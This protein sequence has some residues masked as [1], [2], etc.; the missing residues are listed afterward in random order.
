MVDDADEDAERR[1]G[2]PFGDDN[3]DDDFEP[4]AKKSK[5]SGTFRFYRVCKKNAFS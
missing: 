5:S 3:D 2:R 4:S 1:T